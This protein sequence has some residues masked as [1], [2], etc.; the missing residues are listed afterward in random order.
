MKISTFADRESWKV[1][2][3]GKV[4]GSKLS[5][6]ITKRGNGIKIGVYELIAERLA[7]PEAG[8]LSPMDRGSYLE[9]EALLRFEA[10]T[11]IKVNM[12]LV[13]WTRDDNERMILSPDGY[14]EDL[15]TAV[16]IKCL[17]SARH[18]EA[19]VTGKIPTDYREQVIQYFLVNE[20]LETL[21]F[22]FFD[23]RMTVK[24]FF[25]HTVKR[26]EIQSEVDEY[27]KK[28]KEVL[29]YVDEIVSNLSDF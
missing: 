5:G 4:S 15:K 19:L 14:T 16:E 26:E 8:D 13:I 17:N 18:I 12:S 24:E 1:F 29:E 2:R 11:G 23:P 27:L 3:M 20:E 9:E 6:L 22:V 28:E 10:E 7:I 21:Y 25:Y